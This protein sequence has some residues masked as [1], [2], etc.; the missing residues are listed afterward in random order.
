MSPMSARSAAVLLCLLATAAAAQQ[1]APGAAPPSDDAA[2]QAALDMVMAKHM[3]ESDCEDPASEQM[4]GRPGLIA[5]LSPTAVLYAVPCTF[6]GRN[7][8]YRLYA[9]ETGEIGGLQTLYFAVW[10]DAHGW[11][12]TDLLHN[13]E[14]DGPKLSARFKG[15]PGGDC[16]TAA[17]WTWTEYAYRLDRFAAETACRGRAPADWP[18][19]YP[20]P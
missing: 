20:R 7:L 4:R 5:A 15:G 6:D 8:S 18:V 19:V 14:A 17:E 1:P 3:N 11:T 2:G 9:R 13:V 12:G 16:G 10:S